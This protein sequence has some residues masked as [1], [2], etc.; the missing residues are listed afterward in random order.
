M[1]KIVLYPSQPLF[2]SFRLFRDEIRKVVEYGR[3]DNLSWSPPEIPQD[4]I[5]G[6]E[7]VDIYNGNYRFHYTHVNNL[8]KI[9]KS[10]KI[11]AGK[12]AAWTASSAKFIYNRE[13]EEPKDLVGIIIRGGQTAP[14]RFQRKH[15]KVEE[16]AGIVVIDNL[17]LPRIDD[18]SDPFAH[19]YMHVGNSLL[20][21]GEIYI[22][23]NRIKKIL[24]GLNIRH[25]PIYGTSGNLY[26]PRFISR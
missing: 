14:K 26:Y 23:V 1:D 24:E 15:I 8:Q 20:E 25:L 9:L 4:E 17:E 21:Q 6:I 11:R 5:S 10:Q 16:F 13:Y 3:R 18:W 2:G 19:Q 12:G 22:R 7:P